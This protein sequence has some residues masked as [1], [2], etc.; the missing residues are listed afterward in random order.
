MTEEKQS[1]PGQ[2][3]RGRACLAGGDVCLALERP[4]EKRCQ[5]YDG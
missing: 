4:V 5:S 2:E 3:G 1:K